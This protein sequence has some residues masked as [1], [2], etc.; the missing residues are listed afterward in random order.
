[1]HRVA[2]AEPD[3]DTIQVSGVERLCADLGV[4]PSDPIMLMIAWVMRCETMCVF[5]RQEWS[6]GMTELGCESVE[7]LKG[8]FSELKARLQDPDAFRDYYVYCFGF[9][10]EPGFGVRTLPTPVATQMWQLTLSDCFRHLA[11]W[12]S[13]L[14]EKVALSRAQTQLSACKFAPLGRV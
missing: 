14:E 7:A 13:F 3:E 2:S 4:D 11:E 12:N 10:K 1:M 8:A 9:A 5:T 6:R